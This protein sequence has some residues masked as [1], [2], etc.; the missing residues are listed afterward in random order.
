MSAEQNKALVR[1]YQEAHNSNKLDL[2]DDIVAA[3]IVSHWFTPGVPQGLE[4][5]KMVHKAIAAAFP[6]LDYHIEELV[7]EGDRVMARFTS[8]GTFK[9]E[10]M[11][12]PPNGKSFKIT[13]ISLFRIADGKI[14]EHWANQD[15]LGFYQQLGLT[16]PP[17]PG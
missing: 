16:P 15:D 13:G 4:G 2:L 8:S 7:S 3:D 6:D 5:A 10:L 14:V 17:L 9:G 1:R 11:G 12:I